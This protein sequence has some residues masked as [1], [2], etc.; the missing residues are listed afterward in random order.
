VSDAAPASGEARRASRG[1]ASA[2]GEAA[3]TGRSTGGW[4][5][6][7][8]ARRAVQIAFFLFFVY[9]LFAALQ[10][11]AAFPYADF[12]FRFDP[13]AAFAP[14]VAARHWIGHLSPALITVALAL[15]VGRFWCGWVCPMGTLLGWF[16]FRSARRLSKRVPARLRVVKY[17]VLVAIAAMAALAGMTLLV[18]D[19]ISLLTRTATTS[20]IPGFDYAVT[21]VESALA[22][23]G[24][25]A[26]AV[27]WIE[28]HFRGN[29]L[30]VYQPHYSQSVALFLLFA[31]VVMLN[32]FADRFWCRYLCPLGALLGLVA[33]VQVLRP[34]VGDGCNRCAAC[35]RTCRVDAIE[36]AAGDKPGGAGDGGEAA[37]PGARVVTSECTMCLDCLVAC[38]E[39]E[40]MSFGLARRPGPWTTYDPSR[41]QFVAAAATGAGAVVLLGT[42]V[43]RGPVNPGLIRP[44]GAQNEGAFLSHCLRCS[45]CMKVCPTSGLQPSLGQGGLEALWTPVLASRLGYCDFSCTACGHVCPSGAIPKLTLEKKRQQVIGLAVIDRNRCLP[46]ALDT[47]C[48]VCQEMCPIPDKAIVLTGEHLITRPDGTQDYLAR[49]KVI[50][51]RC[52]GCGICENKCPVAGTSAIVVQPTDPALAAGGGGFGGGTPQG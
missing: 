18:L 13:L 12:F 48:A 44:P 34:I 10:R 16:R 23:W 21:S 52:I 24:L 42:G 26:S 38:P 7:R 27:S 36:V 46:W 45:E 49:P 37:G 35:A 50:A 2:G 14:M 20:L 51:P 29:V 30:P 4:K 3:K 15:V 17:V 5:A 28:M 19:P 6:A 11:R 8:W 43:W 1:S 47:P 33:K 39:R 31:G 40:A 25:G 32:A 22:G 9:L 41:R